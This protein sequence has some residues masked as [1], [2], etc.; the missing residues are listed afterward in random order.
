MIKFTH[1]GDFKKTDTFLGKL[2]NLRYQHILNKYGAQGVEELFPATPIESGETA[3]SWTYEY[4][5]TGRGYDLVYTNTH[6][7]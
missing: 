2:R 4:V 5:D 7:N 3:E 1:H 6:N